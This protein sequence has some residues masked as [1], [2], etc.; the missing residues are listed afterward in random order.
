L[1]TAASLRAAKASTAMIMKLKLEAKLKKPTSKSIEDFGDL[2]QESADRLLA[3]K[4]QI[5]K[6]DGVT[7]AVDWKN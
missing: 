5:Q 6:G 2:D 4:I 7:M 1:H 3:L